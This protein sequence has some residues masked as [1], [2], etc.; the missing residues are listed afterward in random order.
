MAPPFP[1]GSNL[2]PRVSPVR[3]TVGLQTVPLVL[4]MGS[5]VATPANYAAYSMD[6]GLT[7]AA[8]VVPD[9]AGG[10]FGAAFSPSLG[11]GIMISSTGEVFQSFDGITW[12]V[13]AGSNMA[14]RNWQGGV[15]RNS[16][17]TLFVASSLTS[18]IFGTSPD[19][20]TWTERIGPAGSFG[21]ICR[22]CDDDRIIAC[23][24]GGIARSLDGGVTWG[25]ITSPGDTNSDIAWRQDT[26]YIHVCGNTSADAGDTY[27]SNDF[28][29]NWTQQNRDA[30]GD[31]PNCN[32]IAIDPL[33]GHV[34]QG[35]SVTAPGIWRSN[36]GDANNPPNSGN[37]RVVTDA[38]GVGGGCRG[39]YIVETDTILFP[40]HGGSAG[41]RVF[42]N[43][44]STGIWQTI[45]WPLLLVNT[46]RVRMQFLGFPTT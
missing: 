36:A 10:L 35:T 17:D 18:T 3:R 13:F 33:R 34:Y 41:F 28:G 11:Y 25:A 5:A 32:A 31:P 26:D 37:T 9:P 29:G 14:N 12:T 6:N 45:D 40:D 43:V 22:A 19:G 1:L 24:A 46:A 39:G 27:F 4:A 15:V 44:L 21:S 2:D 23:G 16:S 30:A 20:Q 42:R 7:F 8:C 38:S